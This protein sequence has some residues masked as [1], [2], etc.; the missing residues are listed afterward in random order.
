M[1]KINAAGLALIERSEG[2]RLHAYPDPGTDAQPYTIGYGHTQ[3]VY[4]GE[5]ITQAQA[6]AFLEQDVATAEQTVSALVEVM[7]TPNQF[8]ALVSFEYNTGA[9]DGSTLLALV[10]RNDMAGAVEQFGRW[11]WSNGAI[12]PGLVTRRAAEAKLFST[13]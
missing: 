8:A 5:T 7:L 11:V 9:L 2:D 6:I 13:P 1:P 12:L 3:G 4:P 10:N